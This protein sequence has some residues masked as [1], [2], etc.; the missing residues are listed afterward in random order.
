MVT[1]G[2]LPNG[3]LSYKNVTASA[4]G[5]PPPDTTGQGASAT[6]RKYSQE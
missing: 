1:W 4:I 3:M 6:R 2:E 5:I